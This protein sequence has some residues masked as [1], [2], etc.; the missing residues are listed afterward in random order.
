MRNIE[1]SAGR[2]DR[3]KRMPLCNGGDT[4]FNVTRQET[5]QTSDWSLIVREFVESLL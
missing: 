1:R 3:K 4:S 2:G 5:E